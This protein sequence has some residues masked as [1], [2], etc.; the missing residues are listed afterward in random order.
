[1]TRKVNIAL[2]ALALCALL[3]PATASMKNPVERPHKVWGNA[4]V[5]ITNIDLV[6]GF[7]TL[8]T[9]DIGHATHFGR[10][11]NVAE[12]TLY[13]FTGVFEGTG[14]ITTANRDTIRYT[15]QMT[16]PI[17]TVTFEEGTGRFEGVSGQVQ[18]IMEGLDL[19]DFV[20]GAQS[21]FS[22]TATG[23]IKY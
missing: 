7:A 21:S 17:M 1:M 2:L 18:G 23:W 10:C 6:N 3:L 19:S 4:T 9:V 8:K 5:T 13:L 20:V 14:E 11:E 16:I 15:A 12:G 22:Y